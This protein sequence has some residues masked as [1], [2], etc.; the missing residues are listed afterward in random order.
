MNISEKKEV[1]AK[2]GKRVKKVK[3][4]PE[5]GKSIKFMSEHM[6]KHKR[7]KDPSLMLP[8]PLCG[9]K[10]LCSRT[11]GRHK[12]M[13]HAAQKKPC[14]ICNKSKYEMLNK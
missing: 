3:Q 1:T 8:C 14:P 2:E 12:R 13:T 5:C 7:R 10:F 9:Q 11:L 6:A 4:C